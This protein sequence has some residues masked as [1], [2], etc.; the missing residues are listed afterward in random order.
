VSQVGGQWNSVFEIGSRVAAFFG[1]IGD[2]LQAAFGMIIVGISGPVT[3]LIYAAQQIGQALGFDTSGLDVA[4]AGMDA[5]SSEIA[6]GISQNIASAATGFNT[7]IFGDD[8]G[9]NSL[10]QAIAGPLTQTVDDAIASARNAA[11]QIDT[12]KPVNIT[13]T[14]DLTATK[15]VEAIKGIDSRS[16]EGVAEMFRLMRGDTGDDVQEKQLSVLERIAGNTED[17]GLDLESVDL[18]AGA[19]A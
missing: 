9:A 5:F 16:R 12:A 4:L 6:S 17:M 10:G 15:A 18:A 11:D 14:V 19:G 1:A 8:S 2:S 7:A 13:Q 3:G